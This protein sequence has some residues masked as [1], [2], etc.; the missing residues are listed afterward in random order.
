MFVGQYAHGR[1]GKAMQKDSLVGLREQLRTFARERDW[2]QFHTP[3]NLACAVVTEAAEL[4]AHFR[5]AD[6]TGAQRP[7]AAEREAISHEIADVLLFLVRLADKLD[8]DPIVAANEKL[9]I[10]AR[11]Y[12]IDKA[13]G[14]SKKY[15]EL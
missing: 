1:W 8:V 4:L 11:K 9:S 12:P 7:T 6:E 2:D 13:K 5:W 3:K 14:S 15:T 10:N